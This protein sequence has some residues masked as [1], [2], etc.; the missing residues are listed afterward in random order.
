M[1]SW[2]RDITQAYGSDVRIATEPPVDVDGMEGL[3]RISATLSGGIDARRA[4]QIIGRIEGSANFVVVRAVQ[5]RSDLNP[6]ATITLSALYRI[7]A[8]DGAAPP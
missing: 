5:I 8:S 4:L 1:Q 7:R 2:L 3:V 6:N